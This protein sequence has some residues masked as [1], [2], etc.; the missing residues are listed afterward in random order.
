MEKIMG[1]EGKYHWGSTPKQ[2]RKEKKEDKKKMKDMR[3]TAKKMEKML[4][5]RWK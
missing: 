4:K 2:S 5:D 3:K 1:Y